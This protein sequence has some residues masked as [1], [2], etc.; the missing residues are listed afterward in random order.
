M[1]GYKDYSNFRKNYNF[2]M[3]ELT[4]KEDGVYF[5]DEILIHDGKKVAE[6]KTFI[7]IDYGFKNSI[8]KM[9]SNLYPI[10]FTFRGKKVASIESVIQS[11]KYKDK[12]VQNV[13]FKY[14]GLDAYH[15]RG[16]SRIE[17]WQERGKGLLY[18]QG[19]AMNRFSE[20]YQLFIDELFFSAMKNPLYLMALKST[21]DKYLLHDRG[22]IDPH[23]TTLTRYEYELRL[24][25][26]KAYIA[27]NNL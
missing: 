13:I 7:N 10:S 17:P 21:K 3:R 19:K 25:S 27:K 20:E 1:K 4:K 22:L 12:K 26:L 9:L 11:L 23:E 16:A 6:G 14:A 5:G 2:V 15:T 18:W 24:N 8:S